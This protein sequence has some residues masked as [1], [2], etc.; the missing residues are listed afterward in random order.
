MAVIHASPRLASH[1]P[2]VNKTII[3]ISQ[4]EPI[5]TM[6]IN[7]SLKTITSK[8]KRAINKC[9]RWSITQVRDTTTKIGVINN[10]QGVIVYRITSISGL[11]DQRFITLALYTS[12]YGITDY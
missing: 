11:Q 3:N 10:I 5:I 6:I 8:A 1:A 9:C 7:I 2:N 12:D 4:F